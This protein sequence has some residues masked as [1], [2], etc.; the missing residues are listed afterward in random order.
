MAFLVGLI[1]MVQNWVTIKRMIFCW[2]RAHILLAASLA[3]LLDKIESGENMNPTPTKH[4]SSAR[5]VFYTG[6]FSLDPS[7]PKYYILSAS[8]GCQVSSGDDNDTHKYKDKDLDKDPRYVIFFKS[9][10]FKDMKNNISLS[11]TLHQK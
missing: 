1:W 11:K 9:R 8:G 10:G 2:C 3:I 4:N 6:K 5:H 7:F